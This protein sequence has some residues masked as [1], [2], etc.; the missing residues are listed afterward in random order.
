MVAAAPGRR[1][2]HATRPPSRSRWDHQKNR[3]PITTVT[4]P[5]AG[6]PRHGAEIAD[7]YRTPVSTPS[8][9]TCRHRAHQRAGGRPQM[10][11]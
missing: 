5:R 8:H 11:S 9:R 6:E 7:R 1:A 4:K 10:L 2:V 3:A